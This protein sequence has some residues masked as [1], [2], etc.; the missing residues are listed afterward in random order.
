VEPVKKTGEDCDKFAEPIT[1]A[2]SQGD[3]LGTASFTAIE[4]ETHNPQTQTGST[5]KVW[6]SHRNP[7]SD[8]VP[9]SPTSGTSSK[10]H[11]EILMKNLGNRKRKGGSDD[12]HSHPTTTE[13]DTTSPTAIEEGTHN[14]QTQT[15]GEVWRS[16]RNPK[17]NKTQHSQPPGTSSKQQIETLKET[18]GNRKR[19]RGSDSELPHPT[20]LLLDTIIPWPA[21]RD[22]G[23]AGKY[24][25][26]TTTT[27]H[28]DDILAKPSSAATPNL[29]SPA[30]GRAHD[31][32]SQIDTPRSQ[33]DTKK[34]IQ[35]GNETYAVMSQPRS[36]HTSHDY[37]SI[38]V[39]DSSSSSVPVHSPPTAVGK[40]KKKRTGTSNTHKHSH[41]F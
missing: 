19:K 9:N 16:Q 10:Q 31:V 17:S 25:K 40:S 28:Q 37:D 38:L 27:T 4:R 23:F 21:K 15:A 12:E 14:L 6:Q 2:A 35:V 20:T 41:R 33:L 5:D 39:I 30:G 11:V 1:T 29:H 3:N 13:D 36:S 34:C 32:V 18:L 22:G 24:V 26:S 7:K 8:K